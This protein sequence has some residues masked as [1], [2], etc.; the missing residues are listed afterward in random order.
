MTQKACNY[1]QNEDGSVTICGT[2][3]FP[4]DPDYRIIDGEVYVE[5]GNHFG[6][7]WLTEAAVDKYGVRDIAFAEDE[8]DY[9]PDDLG[10]EFCYTISIDH[11][12][13]FIDPATG[14]IEMMTPHGQAYDEEFVAWWCRFPQKMLGDKEVVINGWSDG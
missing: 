13:G 3:Y 11:A 4:D 7:L 6:T 8:D 9:R 5:D 1:H 14:E 12:C 2:T 10:P